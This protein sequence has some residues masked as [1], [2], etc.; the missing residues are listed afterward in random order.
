MNLSESSQ[1]P[2]KCGVPSNLVPSFRGIVEVRVPDPPL[3]VFTKM[4]GMPVPYIS[5]ERDFAEEDG[6]PFFGGDALIRLVAE[7]D[8]DG[9]H[10]EC[11]RRHP[12][13][14]GDQD[15]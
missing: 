8:G 12:G 13:D 14:A 5:V 9:I 4:L 10:E 7:T 15:Y 1:I 11:V 3:A 6:H 2:R